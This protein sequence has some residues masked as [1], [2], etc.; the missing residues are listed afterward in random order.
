MNEIAAILLLPLTVLA[1]SV[2][3]A[4]TTNDPMHL[5]FGAV[6]AIATGYIASRYFG[7]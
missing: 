3:L 5:I 7:S 4:M 1:I 6:L 2:W